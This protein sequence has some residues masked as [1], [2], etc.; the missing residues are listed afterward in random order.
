MNLSSLLSCAQVKVDPLSLGPRRWWRSSHTAAPHHGGGWRCW[1]GNRVNSVL[2]ETMET[3]IHT[4]CDD[5]QQLVCMHLDL[6][7]HQ[8]QVHVPPQLGGEGHRASVKMFPVS[9]F[10]VCSAHF[11]SVTGQTF[12][13][14]YIP[15][16]ERPDHSWTYSLRDGNTSSTTIWC[17]CCSPWCRMLFMCLPAVKQQYKLRR[18]SSAL[19]RRMNIRQRLV[20]FTAKYISSSKVPLRLN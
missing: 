10:W 14:L 3:D 17:E 9:L 11:H 5:I 15:S 19:Y 13:C 6:R 7:L 1:V 16:Q 18:S 12:L 4:F 20:W 8:V 2:I